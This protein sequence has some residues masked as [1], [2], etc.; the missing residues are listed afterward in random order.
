[1]KK[2]VLLALLAFI[3]S[4]SAQKAVTLS[5]FF[6]ENYRTVKL[7]KE[8]ERML[9]I[10]LK[11][12][13]PMPSYK[14]G[15]FFNLSKEDAL[16]TGFTDILVMPLNEDVYQSDKDK[17]T[18][19]LLPLSIN[20]PTVFYT[21]PN[22]IDKGLS[23]DK[24]IFSNPTLK[25]TISWDEITNSDF[26]YTKE[27]IDNLDSEKEVTL[28]SQ[29]LY[30][31]DKGGGSTPQFSKIKM[32]ELARERLHRVSNLFDMVEDESWTKQQW[33]NWFEATVNYQE[34]ALKDCNPKN[35]SISKIYKY[36]ESYTMLYGA[37]T[38]TNKVFGIQSLPYNVDQFNDRQMVII[39]SLKYHKYDYYREDQKQI[40]NIR[41]FESFA[42]KLYFIDFYANWSAFEYDLAKDQYIFKQKKEILSPELPGEQSDYN[43]SHLQTNEN[44]IYAIISNKKTKDYY[45]A[46]LKTQTGETL[47]T[48]SL[49]DLL[50]STDVDFTKKTEIVHLKYGLKNSADFVFGIKHGDDYFL[51]K[52]NQNLTGAKLIKTTSTLN[53]ASIFAN[54]K[55]VDVLKADN[56]VL[57]KISFDAD[58]KTLLSNQRKVIE[59]WYYD[60]DGFVVYDGTQYKLFAPYRLALHSGINL[61]TLNEQLETIKKRCVYQFLPLE[62]PEYNNMMHLQYAAKQNDEWL[63]LFRRENSLKYA[64][65]N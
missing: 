57:Q 58:L 21:K 12:H 39:D 4:V 11:G 24:R 56:G 52:T 47:Q 17:F 32:K 19:E 3:K 40:R 1:M 5:G 65:V 15:Y 43:V 31:T 9:F 33:Q 37:D 55:T 22:H 36:S 2:I 53:G 8:V 25:D 60:E 54:D 7:S 23:Y 38:N 34:P 28:K 44:L 35:Y 45:V 20:E 41:A 59:N 42:N 29:I 49:R 48:K 13:L 64:K 50:A 46:I 10:S 63:L 61:L 18:L 62:D 30:H 26:H 16:K 51:V 27:W 14:S 6:K